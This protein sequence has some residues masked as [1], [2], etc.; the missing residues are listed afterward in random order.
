MQLLKSKIIQYLFYG[1]IILNNQVLIGQIRDNTSYAFLN[2]PS[3]PTVAALGGDRVSQSK[4]TVNSFL[5]NPALLDSTHQNVLSLNYMPYFQA[6]QLASVAYAPT[7]LG[8][9]WGIGVQ[10][11]DYGKLQRTDAV[12]NVLGEFSANDYA[13]TIA[14]SQRQ[15]N[16]TF[17]GSLK[18]VGSVIEQLG[19][20]AVMLDVGGYFKHPVYD[21]TY[22][23]AVKNIGF[24]LKEFSPTSTSNLPFDVQM[25][26]S[27]KPQYMPARFSLNAH[28]LYQFD[29]AY[30]NPSVVVKDLN[31][32]TVSTKVSWPD[33]IARHLSFGAELLLSKHVNLLLGYNHLLN[34]ELSLSSAAGLSGFSG[35]IVIRSKIFELY[36]SYS[37]YHASGNLSSFGIILD[38]KRLIK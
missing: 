36:Y 26:V 31:G 16:I 4:T 11:L 25:G 14:T 2:I 8:H 13:I 9:T 34:R 17:G 33:K 21:L 20:S 35:G 1:I 5:Q 12:G 7:I 6:G 38:L 24:V 22:G 30:A 28:H 15:G 27:F 23:I 19:S 10:Y 3:N 32:N 37:G 18:Y 29:I